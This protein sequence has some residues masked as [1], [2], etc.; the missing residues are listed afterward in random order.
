MSEEFWDEVERLEPPPRDIKGYVERP[1]LYGHVQLY[2]DSA[3]VA[4]TAMWR[5]PSV[6]H[7]LDDVPAIHKR[8]GMP[9]KKR[10]RGI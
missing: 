10:Y 5:Y 4:V 3:S 1:A 6:V 9:V 8:S 2:E 7:A